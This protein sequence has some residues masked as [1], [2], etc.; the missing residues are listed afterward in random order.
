MATNEYRITVNNKSAITRSFLLFSDLPQLSQNVTG[1]YVNVW[2]KSALVAGENGRTEFDITAE[3]FAV[4]GTTPTPLA[5]GV[6]VST[7]DFT[8]VTVTGAKPGTKA[9]AQ[10]DDQGGVAFVPPAGTTEVAHAFGIDILPYSPTDNIN[11][12][13]SVL[14]AVTYIGTRN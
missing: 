2:E 4:C 12:A 7:G 3:Q 9:I 1:P 14:R 8:P 13:Y 5:Q 11:R 6:V 10:V